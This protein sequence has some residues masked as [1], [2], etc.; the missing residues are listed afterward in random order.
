MHKKFQNITLKEDDEQEFDKLRHIGKGSQGEA[1][2][3]KYKKSGRFAVIKTIDMMKK[4]REQRKEIMLEAY[5]LEALD[6]PY[7]L[8]Y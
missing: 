3:I 1:V 4:T 7:I 2:Q 8:K 5:I 6:H